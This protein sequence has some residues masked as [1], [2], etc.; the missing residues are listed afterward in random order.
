[1]DGIY[2]HPDL[3]ARLCEES[4]AHDLGFYLGLR[5]SRAATD[6][7]EIGVGA[8]RVAIPLARVGA[9]VVGID[10]AVPMLEELSRRIADEPAEVRAR[11]SVREGD[12]RELDL[13]ERFDLIIV[14]FNGA[15]EMLADG[16]GDRFLSL[17]REHLREGGA[18]AFDVAIPDRRLWKGVRSTTPWFEDGEAGALARCTQRL[19]YDE[20]ARVLTVTAEERR[21]DDD[22]PRRVAVLRQR[23][24]EEDEVREMLARHGLRLVWRTRRFALPGQAEGEG[25]ESDAVAFVAEPRHAVL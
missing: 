23:Q 12:A 24:L 4:R 17:A 20:Q 14:P 22:A 21:M 1:M 16:G 13:A 15:A 5:R 8:G 25:E 9:R 18:L 2:Q 19:D 6:V 3:Y 11:V 7:L 10:R